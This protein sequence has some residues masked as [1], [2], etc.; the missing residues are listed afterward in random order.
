M[1]EDKI[2]LSVWPIQTWTVTLESIVFENFS[3]KLYFSKNFKI[4]IKCLYF[5]TNKDLEQ[6]FY[7]L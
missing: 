7:G 3:I 2:A 1:L 5:L 6:F 4:T